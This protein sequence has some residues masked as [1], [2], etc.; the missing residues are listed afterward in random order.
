MGGQKNQIMEDL[1]VKSAKKEAEV[2][3][4]LY[5]FQSIR[6]QFVKQ[7]LKDASFTPDKGKLKLMLDSGHL[8][9]QQYRSESVLKM[10]QDNAKDG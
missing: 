10:I 3:A 1:M 5:E 2:E 6:Q 7:M 8:V 4:A 9:C